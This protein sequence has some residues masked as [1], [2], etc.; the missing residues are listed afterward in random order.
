MFT[1]PFTHQ[2]GFF[3]LWWVKTLVNHPVHPPES[4]IL[5][6]SP[7]PFT[8]LFTKHTASRWRDERCSRAH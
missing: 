5:V 1:R 3:W 2:A 8:S 6:N 4:P 7:G